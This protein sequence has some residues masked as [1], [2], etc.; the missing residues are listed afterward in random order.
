MAFIAKNVFK[1]LFFKKVGGNRD[2]YFHEIDY[3]NL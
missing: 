2:E 1:S 3:L